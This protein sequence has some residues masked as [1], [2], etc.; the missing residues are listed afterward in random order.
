[1]PSFDIPL[2]GL[3]ADSTALNTIA[4][5]LANMN[6]TGFKAQT[7]TFS[8]LLSQN[9]GSSGSGN[10]IQVGTGVQVASN[11][12]DFTTGNITS[13]VYSDAAINGTGFFVL[14]GGGGAQLLTRDG[15]FT[16]SN[17]GTLES[18]GGQAVMG[19][20][21]VNGVV[22]SS[23]TVTDINIPTGE[24]MKPFATTTFSITQNL[25][26]TTPAGGT[27]SSTEKVF[28]SLG[29]SYDA[30]VTYTNIS[31]P[32]TPNTW[33]YNIVLPETLTPN[34]S[35]PGTVTYSFGIGATVDPGTNLE[36]SGPTAGGG[37]ATTAVLAPAPGETLATYVGA[38]TVPA[39]PGPP[40]IPAVPATGIYAQLEAAGILDAGPGSVSLTATGNV[41]TI[42]GATATSGSVIQDAAA[43][44]GASGTLTFDSSGNLI[45]PAADI[46]GIT[47]SGLADGAAPM[48]MTWNLFGTDGASNLSQNSA[49]SSQ[50]A[51]DQN[52]YAAGEYQT[53]SIGSDGTLT[54]SYSNGQNQAI[55][56]LAVATVNNQQGLS[57]VGSD[58][59]Q[60]T[61]TS[62][63]ASMGVAGTGGRGA[64]EGGDTEAS[65][66]NISQEFSDLIVAQRAFEANSKAVTTFDTVTQ[67]TINMIH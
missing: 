52:G 60:A 23:G 64:I 2:S 55:G 8:D 3:N 31:T 33:S 13:G 10:P 40:A 6:T 7:T 59:Y 47:F 49:A 25:Q 4:N 1:M 35:V 38:L 20:A 34:T 14:D 42:T 61:S 48:D 63:G 15:N 39:V 17:N 27:T 66:V 18:A 41:L 32:T 37:T 12:T 56:Q 24:V 67:E 62:G 28:D 16:V 36:I 45:S 22:N 26:S 19:Y 43:S 11:S 5:N 54:A 57:S 53:F 9:L 50:S 44:A 46:S 21:A 30:T 58:D 51:Q 65:N 29:N